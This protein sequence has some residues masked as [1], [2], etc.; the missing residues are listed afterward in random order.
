MR[1]SPSALLEMFVAGS[2]TPAGI[3]VHVYSSAHHGSSLVGHSS[4]C[5]SLSASVRDSF[6]STMLNKDLPAASCK[7]WLYE[8][9]KE[10]RFMRFLLEVRHPY[11]YRYQSHL[12]LN[13]LFLHTF[14]SYLCGKANLIEFLFKVGE[15]MHFKKATVPLSVTVRMM[16]LRSS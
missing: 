3:T 16:L 4:S 11:T 15:N 9:I 1:D 6:I 2:T 14:C 8:D 5:V 12:I 10:A 13:F 7:C